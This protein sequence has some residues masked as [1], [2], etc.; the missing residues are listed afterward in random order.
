MPSA[1]QIDTNGNV[2]ARIFKHPACHLLLPILVASAAF[3]VLHSMSQDIDFNDVIYD[4]MTYPARLLLASL[5]AMMVSYLSFSMYDILI[6]PSVTPIKLP[7]HIQLMTAGSSMAVSNMLGFTWVTGAAVRLRV[8][9]AF[10]VKIS[11]IAKL[12]AISWVAF[13]GGLWAL[14]G[15][16]ML[17]RPT[18]VSQL[19]TIFQGSEQLIGTLMITSLGLFF[20]WTRNGPKSVQAGPINM[21][22]PAAKDGLKLTAVSMIDIVA[23]AATL[24]FLMPADLSQ[25]FVYFLVI[26]AAAF[27]LGII[28]HSPGGLG[29]FEATLIAG[30][31]AVGRSD[32]L[33]AIAIYRVIYTVLPFFIAVIGLSIAWL[34]SNRR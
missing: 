5:V 21:E 29:V 19:F 16:L 8:Y 10:G 20:W 2:I 25:N 22:V 14:L 15:L 9:S 34:L 3:W 11:A 7:V 26:F 31:G 18:G 1:D 13:T 33:A 12:I 28:S 23:M 17:L 4:A 30:L 27:W 6:M 32:A 24:Y